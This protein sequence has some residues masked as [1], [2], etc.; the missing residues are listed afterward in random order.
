VILSFSHRPAT[1]DS[2]RGAKIQLL[3]LLA[4]ALD[5]AA[6]ANCE[7]TTVLGNEARPTGTT[8]NGVVRRSLDGVRRTMHACRQCA[9]AIGRLLALCS[10]GRASERSCFKR[11]AWGSGSWRRWRER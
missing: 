1:A 5:S 7:D 2:Y 4:K 8:T 6:R 3:I 10:F 9:E 11:L